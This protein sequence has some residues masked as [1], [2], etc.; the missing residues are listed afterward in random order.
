MR[1]LKRML[2]LVSATVMSGICVLSNLTTVSAVKEK[3]GLGAVESSQ[4]E[5]DDLYSQFENSACSIDY[6]NISNIPTAC[7]LSTNE[8][9]IYF[10]PIG[11]QGDI[12]SCTA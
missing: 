6:N 7:D 9:S 3:H 4:A 11:H 10:P 5:W 2:S 12:S 1:K 8:D